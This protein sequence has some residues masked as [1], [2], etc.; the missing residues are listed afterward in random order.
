[1]VIY[2]LKHNYDYIVRYKIKHNYIYICS[3]YGKV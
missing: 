2:K 1:M 3:R